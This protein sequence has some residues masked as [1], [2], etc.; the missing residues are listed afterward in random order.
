MPWEQVSEAIGVPPIITYAA[1][2]L[3]NFRPI[4]PMKPLSLEYQKYPTC[5]HNR[6]T[7]TIIT[8]SGSIDESWFYLIQ[9]AID[10]ESG[11]IFRIV[12]DIARS[13]HKSDFDQMHTL[14]GQLADKIVNLEKIM[15]RMYEENIPSVFYN[16]VRRYLSGWLNDEEFPDGVYYGVEKVGRKYAGGSA[17][18]NPT[19]Q[20]LD[21]AFGIRH[22]RKDHKG[23]VTGVTS[24]GKFS[25]EMRQYMVKN[26]REFLHWL[27]D[28]INIRYMVD[29]SSVPIAVKEKFNECLS[30]LRTFRDSHLV[31]V[32]TYVIAQ[33]QKS[34]TTTPAKGTGGSNAIAF[35]KEIR[36]HM[37]DAYMSL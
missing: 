37:D 19:I 20:A 31:M 23:I 6:N 3:F 14:L 12:F 5:L 28:N 26:H 1:T 33:A 36:S 7:W 16:R 11:G 29:Q 34:S 25:L 22:G 4:D 9:L 17:A 10:L 13:S 21:I 24:A 18:Q 8:G 32:A 27:E 2:V 15:M 30:K 35:L